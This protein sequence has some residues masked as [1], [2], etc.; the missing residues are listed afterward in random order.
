MLSCKEMPDLS[1]HFSLA[2]EVLKAADR[3]ELVV[4]T[5]L[6]GPESYAISLAHI[7]QILAFQIFLDIFSTCYECMFLILHFFMWYFGSSVSGFPS[8]KRTRSPE[9]QGSFSHTAFRSI[10]V[11]TFC[12]LLGT[13][14]SKWGESKPAAESASPSATWHHR[15]V[16]KWRGKSVNGL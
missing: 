5:W 2:A 14:T 6:V 16:Q 1:K 3:P 10:L 12:A 4:A 9:H 8:L 15:E 13:S 7:F 11:Y